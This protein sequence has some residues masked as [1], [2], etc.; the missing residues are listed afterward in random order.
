MADRRRRRS[1]SPSVAPLP[2]SSHHRLRLPPTSPFFPFPPSLPLHSSHHHH[3]FKRSEQV[4]AASVLVSFLFLSTSHRPPRVRIEREHDMPPASPHSG[5]RRAGAPLALSSLS[6]SRLPTEKE[7]R[8]REEE[9]EKKKRKRKRTANDST[10][11]L[12]AY[13]GWSF[14][15][16]STSTA[17]HTVCSQALCN[18][19]HSVTT[20]GCQSNTSAPL[21]L[22]PPPIS[23]AD[24]LSTD[25]G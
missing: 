9:E 20:H 2:L 5:N 14:T 11:R 1:I 18:L 19:S 17:G 15:I 12:D 22:H 6:P 8:N 23:L 10:P 25:T 21:N 4:L 24:I 13:N 16:S 7:K 3:F